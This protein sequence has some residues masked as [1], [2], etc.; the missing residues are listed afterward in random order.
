MNLL[1][2]FLII[3][4]VALIFW[5][6]AVLRAVDW[7]ITWCSFHRVCGWCRRH[8][9]G[10]PFAKVSHTICPLCAAAMHDEFLALNDAGQ[11]QV[12]DNSYS[13]APTATAKGC[14][15]RT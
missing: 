12:G 8:Q 15:A 7:S 3:T 14:S 1:D 4:A 5:A 9:S 13:P 10:N 11:S 6:D 2:L